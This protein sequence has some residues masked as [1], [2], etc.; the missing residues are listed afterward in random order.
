MSLAESAK[1]LLEIRDLEYG[2]QTHGQPIPLFDSLNLV[3]RAGEHAVIVGGSGVGKSTLVR[4]VAQGQSPSVWHAEGFKPV[5][6]I[7]EGGLIDDLSVIQNLRLIDRHNSVVA[8]QGIE[9]VLASLNVGSDKLNTLASEL[10]GGQKRRVALARALLLKP[11]V[12][13]FDE[14]DA[15]LDV[16][17]LVDLSNVIISERSKNSACISVSHNPIYIASV[18]TH[19]YQLS[20]GKLETLAEWD[21]VAT[22]DLERQARQ[23][24]IQDRLQIKHEPS[25][26][27]VPQT[28]SIKSNSQHRQAS[29]LPQVIQSAILVFKSILTAPRSIIESFKV[30]NRTLMLGFVSGVV[31]FSLV[32]MMLGATTLAVVKLLSD[33]AIKGVVAWFIGPSNLLELMRGRFALYLGPAVGG[34]LFVAR[35]GSLICSWLGELVR[36]RRLEALS[37]LGVPVQSL[38]YAPVFFSTLVAAVGVILLFTLAVWFGGV[39]AAQHLFNVDQVIRVLSV[40]T[41]DIALSQLLLKTGIYAFGVATIITAFASITKPNSRT[42]SQHTTAAIVYATLFIALVELVLILS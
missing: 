3:L 26:D 31:F 29:L 15:G 12:I 21:T 2:Y 33:N 8:N 7:Q 19:V 6:V 22:T 16:A 20:K 17:N 37:Y 39:V 23:Q 38:Y 40:S 25:L 24:F 10:S 30:F 13:I 11:K 5:V 41:Y 1:I 36:S 18:A 32:G 28:S 42:V 27:A 34:M 35:S 14:P 4:I 9:E